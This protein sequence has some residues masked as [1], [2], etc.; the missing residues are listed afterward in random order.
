MKHHKNILGSSS[1]LVN[2]TRAAVLALVLT[3]AWAT[4]YEKPPTLSA[5]KVFPGTPLKGKHYTIESKVRTDGFLTG[6]EIK[7]EFGNFV[8][9]GPGMLEIRLHEIDALVKLKT[10]EASEEFQRGAKASANEKWEGLKQVYDKPKEAAAG[11]SKGVSRFFKRTVRASKTGVQTVNDAYHGRT[12]GSIEGAGANLPGK[13]QS[14]A[15]PE[16]ESKYKKAAKASG[17]TAVNILGFDDSRRKLAKRLGVDPYTTNPILDE[18]LD[19]VTWSIFAGDF[20]IDLATSLIPGSIVVTTSSLVTNWVWD[21][22]PGDLRVKIEQTLLKSGISQE[23]VDRLLRHRAYPLSYQAALTSALDALG[24]VDGH[25]DIMPLVLSVTTVDQARFVVNTMRMLKR[26]HET[27]EP[28]NFIAVQGTVYATNTKGSIVIT[29]PADY[30][31]WSEM[32]DNFS[33]QKKFTGQK[34]ELHIAGSMSEMAKSHF[35]ER[36]WELHENSSLFAN[37]TTAA[38]NGK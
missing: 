8:A 21:T 15:L 30:V 24:K 25:E 36:G 2:L 10:F 29:A 3:P 33:G 26:Y 20:G 11:I 28:L 27:V 23:D 9:L 1:A 35:E 19:E 16:S 7:S 22:P 5:A 34:H 6:A 18:K 14:Q 12:P 37:L 17:S 4:D 38:K 13:A 31:S 32:M